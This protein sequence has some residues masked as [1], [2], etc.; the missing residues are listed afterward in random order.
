MFAAKRLVAKMPV[1]RTLT[2]KMMDLVRPPLS[3]PLLV[4]ECPPSFLFG[5]DPA[6]LWP[7]TNEA[8]K[9]NA[10]LSVL[11]VV[12]CDEPKRG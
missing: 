4:D 8:E 12:L 6:F 10:F 7:L 9:R 11:G 3:S 5:T 1:A 2:V